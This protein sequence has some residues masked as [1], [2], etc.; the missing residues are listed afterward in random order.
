MYNLIILPVTLLTLTLL[1]RLSPYLPEVP[2]FHSP[3]RSHLPDI[4]QYK[5]LDRLCTRHTQQQV[6]QVIELILII[7]VR[8]E[9]RV[10]YRDV[11]VDELEDEHLEDEG[12]LEGVEELVV[13]KVNV[14][15][16]RVGIDEVEDFNEDCV[17]ETNEK[18]KCTRAF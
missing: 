13:L 11:G 10:E 1:D 18:V 15:G 16:G 17:H 4:F 6:I 7:P 9:G 14:V 8:D 3:E 2:P 5:Y 12:L